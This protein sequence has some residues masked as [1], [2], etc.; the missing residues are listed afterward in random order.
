MKYIRNISDEQNKVGDTSNVFRLNL[1]EDTEL[2]NFG[3]NNLTVNVANGSG[4]VLSLTPKKETGNTVID[5]D[6]NDAPLKSLT[7]DNYLLEVE[8]KFS[9]GTTA[10]F[11]TKGGMPFTVNGNLK[12]T[13][14]TLVPTVTFDNVLDAVDEKIAV[15]MDTVKVGP[16]G[17]VGPAGNVDTS[18]D[19]TFT[20]AN[21]FTQLIDGYTKTK[22][23]PNTDVDLI[24]TPGKYEVLNTY[25]HI[26]VGIATA[27]VMYV[28]NNVDAGIQYQLLQVRRNITAGSDMY[29]RA[30][31]LGVW[32]PWVKV[33]HD[34]E[35]VHNTG[36]ETIAGDKTFTGNNTFTN[37]INGSLSTRPATFTDFAD[38]A[39]NMFKYAGNWYVM[40]KTIANDPAVSTGGLHW[41]H[42]IVNPAYGSNTGNIQIESISGTTYNTGVDAGVLKGWNLI[43]KDSN[44]VHNTGTETIN[45]DKTFRSGN[46]GLRVTSTG[47]QKTSDNGITWAN[48]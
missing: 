27:G 36:T 4:Y 35:V 43:P 13:S 33:A 5:L 18:H 42:V 25:T 8:V 23:A 48:I 45:G 14:G 7:P 19:N 3:E 38:V 47:I 17:P 46:Y 39:K 16:E 22:V 2:F 26:P 15:Y 10:T 11:P 41:Y 20:G 40:D 6:F 29:F 9:D 44:L 28:E 30:G 32:Q 37:L 21:T 34:D 1:F 24:L 31:R 12:E